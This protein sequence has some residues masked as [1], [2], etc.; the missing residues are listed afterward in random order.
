MI[1]D[2]YVNN[3]RS[4]ASR[5]GYFNL[6]V[7]SFLSQIYSSFKSIFDKKKEKFIQNRSVINNELKTI[8]K[9]LNEKQQKMNKTKVE[10]YHIF[11][12]CALVTA[13]IGIVSLWQNLVWGNLLY[14]RWIV[15]GTIVACCFFGSMINEYCVKMETGKKKSILFIIEATAILFTFVFSLESLEPLYVVRSALYGSLVGIIIYTINY[16][17][18]P[19]INGLIGVVHNLINLTKIMFYKFTKYRKERVLEKIN[20]ELHQIDQQQNTITNVTLEQLSVDYMLGQQ[21]NKKHN[22]ENPMNKIDYPL[23]DK[24]LANA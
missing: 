16:I 23:T 24:E 4:E 13:F 17:F 22:Y 8:I 14:Q 3:L 5:L 6:P 10:W 15:Y 18:F 12:F 19:I 11:S 2:E 7:D 21:A 9:R 20:T 1:N